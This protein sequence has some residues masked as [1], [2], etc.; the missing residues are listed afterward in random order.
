MS[1][2]I[3]FAFLF[4]KRQTTSN[5]YHARAST[6]GIR[7]DFDILGY[8]WYTL[9]A[10]KVKVKDFHTDVKLAES[11]LKVKVIRDFVP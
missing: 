1:P 2:L 5:S 10:S 8:L 9:D 6:G 7:V 11:V 3:F 4:D